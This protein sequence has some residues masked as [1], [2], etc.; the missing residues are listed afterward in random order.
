MEALGRL[1]GGIAHDFNNILVSISGYAE[2]LISTLPDGAPARDD[3][4]EIRLETERGAALTRQLLTLS[5]KQEMQEQLVDVNKVADEAEKMLG[6][7]IGANMQLEIQLAP[8][9]ALISA[10]PSQIS[11]VIMNLVIN[12]R[13]AMPEGGRIIIETGK[14]SLVAGHS[15]MRL[16]PKAGDSPGAG[17]GLSTVYGIVNQAGGGIS[18][19][20]APGRGATFKIYFP[21]TS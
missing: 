7:I 6:R 2:F 19:E 11:Q 1:A 21:R 4:A 8:E 20:S 18:I 13:D 9:P 10:D 15:G 5:R 16:A 12:A 14:A 17:L 3:L